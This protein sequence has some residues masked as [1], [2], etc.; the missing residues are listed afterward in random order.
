[1]SPPQRPTPDSTVDG[2]SAQDRRTGSREMVSKLLAERTE[3]FVLYCRL[4]GLAPYQAKPKNGTHEML[5][6][7]C[8]VLVDYIAAGHFSVYERIISGTERR[9]EIVELSADLYPRIAETTEA[10]LAFNDQYDTDARFELSGA[11]H[12][13]LSSLGEQLATRIELEDKLLKI[14]G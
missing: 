8:Q 13:S 6:E 2:V 3:M 12:E 14:L 4:A 7:F 10:V 5:Q 9:K 1:M 11:F